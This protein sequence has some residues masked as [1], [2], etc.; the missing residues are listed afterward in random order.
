MRLLRFALLIV[1]VFVAARVAAQ[2]SIR[3]DKYP[4]DCLNEEYSKSLVLKETQKYFE[5]ID[6]LIESSKKCDQG[7]LL[8]TEVSLKYLEL[9]DNTYNREQRG[10]SRDKSYY[11]EKGLEWARKS[12]QADSTY[13]IGYE[14]I[15]TS[16]AAIVS[17]SGLR[18]QSHLADSVRIYAEKALHYGPENDRAIHILGRWHY[19]V[20]KLSWFTKFMAGLLFGNK[21]DGDINKAIDYFKMSVDL[22]DFPVHRYWLGKAYLEAGKKD[23]AIKEFEYLQTLPYAQKNDEYFKEEARK[24]IKK[25]S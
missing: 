8:Y 7:Y 5:E 9:G 10:D 24:L 1:W 21:P 16:Y 20:S 13:D 25:Y 11:F 3:T 12:I 6:Q 15:S 19:E 22:D 2:D 17:V 4:N 23:K 14:M 18:K